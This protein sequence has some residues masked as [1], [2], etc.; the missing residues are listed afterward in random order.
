M[1]KNFDE[2]VRLQSNKREV[3][4][5][6]RRGER[7][8][9]IAEG[10]SS[11]YRLA[12]SS[13]ASFP[14][15]NQCPGTDC[16]LTEQEER[17]DS[18]CQ[19][20]CGKRKDGQRDED[21]NESQIQE[22]CRLVGAAETTKELAHG[23]NLQQKNLNKLGLLKRKESPQC[24][25]ESGLQVRQSRLCQKEQS[26]QSRV[27]DREGEKSQGERERHLC[28]RGRRIRARAWR[29]KGRLHSEERQIP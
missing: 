16:D 14:G 8:Q 22:K 15:V 27:P 24:H 1:S 13:A 18:S 12:S 26:R 10:T 17:E 3:W 2:T 5:R 4:K 25:R 20:V 9:G 11:A 23:R 6:E 19:R 7:L 28:E 21:K 29:G